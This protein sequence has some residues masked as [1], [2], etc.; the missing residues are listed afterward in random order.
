MEI[1]EVNDILE[2]EKNNIMTLFICGE[3]H[4]NLA[5]FN[6][7]EKK[8]LFYDLINVTWSKSPEVRKYLNC[9]KEF[10]IILMKNFDD[11]FTRFEKDLNEYYYEEWISSA[12][13]P[14][15]MHLTPEKM[16]VIFQENIPSLIYHSSKKDKDCDEYRNFY[17]IA[18]LFKVMF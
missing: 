1:K 6:I 17:K 16:Q 7:I 12:T 18:K 5:K 4:T 14:V 9:T 15:V 11:K 13:T 3:K 2:A 8:T 10:E